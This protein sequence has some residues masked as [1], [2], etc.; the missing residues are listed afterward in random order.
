MVVFGEA[1]PPAEDRPHRAVG[2]ESFSATPLSGVP[3]SG[4]CLGSPPVPHEDCG[5]GRRPSYEEN[6]TA[7]DAR[8]AIGPRDD[9]GHHEHADVERFKNGP[10][11][12][13]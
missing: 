9:C 5:A 11:G 6:T 7:D 1:C 10:D 4:W 13:N 2:S 12:D 8:H 3:T